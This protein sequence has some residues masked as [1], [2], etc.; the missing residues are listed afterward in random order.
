MYVVHTKTSVLIVEITDM[1]HIRHHKKRFR[2]VLHSE[3]LDAR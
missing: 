2:S 1:L 3:R